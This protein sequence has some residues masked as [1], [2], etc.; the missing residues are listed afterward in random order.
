MQKIIS[1]DKNKN[2]YKAIIKVDNFE[3]KSEF[4]PS[5]TIVGKYLC[6]LD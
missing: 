6:Y 2:L 4:I 3:E 5:Q 1:V